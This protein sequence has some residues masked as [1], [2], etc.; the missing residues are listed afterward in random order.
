M[1]QLDGSS[2]ALSSLSYVTCA[3]PVCTSRAARSAGSIGFSLCAILLP[4]RKLLLHRRPRRRQ[5]TQGV[6]IVHL[7]QNLVGQ[8][9]SIDPPATVQRSAGSGPK[10][11]RM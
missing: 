6:G 7:A 3:S 11:G 8:A 9:D 4:R 1:S 5:I 2:P 10:L